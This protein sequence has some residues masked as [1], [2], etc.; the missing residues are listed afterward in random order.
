MNINHSAYT[1]AELIERFNKD[2]RVNQE[3]QRSG[4]VWPDSA[5]AYFVDTIL[6]G[7]PFP[8][9]YFYQVY[10]KKMKKPM[11]EIVDGQQRIMTIIG[12]KNNEFRLT[13]SSQ[14]YAGLSFAELPEEVQ[15]KYL[16]TS[17]QVDVIL[18][19]EKSKLLEMFRR[20]NAYTAPLN[21]AEKRHSKYQGRFKWYVTEIADRI[22]GILEEYKILTPKQMIR[23]ADA[24]YIAELL[25]VLDSG[26]VHKS[27]PA[28]EKIYKKYDTKY[29]VEKDYDAV[30]TGFFNT[31][32]KDFSVLKDTHLMKTYALHSFFT[33]FAHITHGIPNG[34][35]DLGF[36]CNRREVKKDK[37]TIERLKALAYAQEIKDEEGEYG[38]YVKASISTT[39]KANQR[40]VRAKLIASIINPE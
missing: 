13:S 38:N 14:N 28:I 19:T 10:D 25:I 36:P 7:Y 5:R 27:A 18:S 34:E 26:I 23:M 35:A 37:N 11:M 9:L 32:V 4:Q 33:A 15:E 22:S 30:I 21:S 16:M 29:P 12:F 1:I 17:V 24:E 6:E 8:K 20:I 3:Y 40:K 39:T 31:L 2:I